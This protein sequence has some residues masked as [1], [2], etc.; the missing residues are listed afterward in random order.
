MK[1]I[2]DI[3]KEVKNNNL[4]YN[5][6][7]ELYIKYLRIRLRK[8]KEYPSVKE[9]IDYYMNTS[10][11]NCYGYALRLKLPKYFKESFYQ[12][13]DFNIFDIDPGVLSG[14]TD[15]STERKLLNAIYS[16]LDILKIDYTTDKY[17]LSPYKIAV[18]QDTKQK[19]V[20]SGFPPDYHF[21]RLNKEGIWTYK[22]GYE[23]DVIA[24][25]KPTSNEEY[26]LIKKISIKR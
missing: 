1:S 6:L 5:E 24:S 3:E 23:G 19:Y 2:K 25:D 12:V 4:N 21:C 14:I 11:I 7:L 18:F 10:D 17:D 9:E 13:M 26:K 16:D 20:T 22:N 8:L 15:I